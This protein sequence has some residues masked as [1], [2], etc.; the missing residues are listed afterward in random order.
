MYQPKLEAVQTGSQK[1]NARV[2]S[3]PAAER[4]ARW[5]YRHCGKKRKKETTGASL[6]DRSII[7]VFSLAN[8]VRA[9][10]APP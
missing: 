9:G 3:V 8:T 6:A 7:R 2:G 5:G 1:R 4:S 10:G